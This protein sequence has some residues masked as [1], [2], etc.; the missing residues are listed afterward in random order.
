[1][2][3]LKSV[4]QSSLKK[5]YITQAAQYQLKFVVTPTQN[6]KNNKTK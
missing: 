3:F 1:M 4:C 2:K 5:K 6:T